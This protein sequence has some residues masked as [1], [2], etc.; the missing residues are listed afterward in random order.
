L[1]VTRGWV[2]FQWKG[3]E[4]LVPAGASCD[5][6]RGTGPGIPWFDDASPAFKEALS[7]D[8][9]DATLAD[10]RVR[11]TLSLWH[12]I[13]RV[14]PEDRARV[15]DRIAELVRIPPGISRDRALRLDRGELER[16][17]DELAWKW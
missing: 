13:F 6:R 16:L 9:L 5:I 4:S 14:P 10:A 11:D 12:L 1:S 2:S 3:L 7:R 8:E 17:K 15:Y